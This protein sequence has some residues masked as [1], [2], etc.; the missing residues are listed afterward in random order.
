MLG[1]FLRSGLVFGA[2]CFIINVAAC[3]GTAAPA[4]G[5]GDDGGSEGGSSSSSSGGSGSS[6]A[7]QGDSGGTGGI[8]SGGDS[9]TEL[10]SATGKDATASDSFAGDS[11]GGSDS[12]TA[13]DAPVDSGADATASGDASS[14]PDAAEGGASDSATGPEAEAD[15]GAGCGAE[16]APCVNNGIRGLCKAGACSACVGG[17]CTVCPAATGEDYWVDPVGGSD[18][19][20]TGDGTTLGCAYK[21]ITRALQA[22]G[23][24]VTATTVTVLGPSTVMAG[25]TFPIVLPT[26]VTLTAA[27]GAVVVEVPAGFSGFTLS[28]AGAGIDGSAAG[29]TISGQSGGANGATFGIVADT[30]TGVTTTNAPQISNVVVTG[31]LDDGILVEH[32]GLLQI[33]PGVTST[34][35]GT[36]AARKAGLHITGTG[37]AIIEVAPEDD[38]THFD[39]NTNHGIL[40]DATGSVTVSG[41]VTNAAAGLGTVTTNRNYAAGVWIEQTPDAPPLNSISGLVSFG[42]TS[43]NG[44]RVVAGSNAKLRSC[45]SLGNAEDG[46][47]VSGGG[48][49]AADDIS[50][51]DLGTPSDAGET[52]GGNTFQAPL[53]AGNNG[54]AGLCLQVKANSGTLLAAG[55]IFAGFNCAASA[56]ILTLNSGACDNGACAGGVCDLGIVNGV[57]NAIDVSMCAP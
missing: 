53:G 51:I 35:N 34:S 26:N 46:L 5:L 7:G 48:G 54:S 14:A 41:T 8:D 17:V 47:I 43:G 10:D 56:G 11:A 23:S 22:I 39:G 4:I 36:T 9:A 57:G 32:L 45:A 6:E 25:E 33:G 29:L 40:V 49:V 28:A 27:T 24:P 52:F 3:G 18:Q 16:N 12:A 44:I 55:N 42:N 20:G 30:G 38:P 19:T 15:T 50:G 31:F 21:T 2:L 1:R 37:Q 13:Q